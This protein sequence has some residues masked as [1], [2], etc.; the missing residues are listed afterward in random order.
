[1]ETLANGEGDPRE[2]I[3][4]HSRSTSRTLQGGPAIAAQC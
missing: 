1:M 4:S 2:E 3:S